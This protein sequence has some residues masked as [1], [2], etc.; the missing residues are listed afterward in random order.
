M[1]LSPLGFLA[2]GRVDPGVSSVMR[3]LCLFAVSFPSQ[4][5]SSLGSDQEAPSCYPK[6]PGFYPRPL[7]TGLPMVLTYFRLDLIG[8][9]KLHAGSES[10]AR[11]LEMSSQGNEGGGGEVGTQVFC[12]GQDRNSGKEQIEKTTLNPVGCLRSLR[13]QEN[14]MGW[15]DRKGYCW[16]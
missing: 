4:A 5:G 15:L 7:A 3:M 8:W 16:R 13:T 2:S 1:A 9:L 12:T 6:A 14:S 11:V 10:V